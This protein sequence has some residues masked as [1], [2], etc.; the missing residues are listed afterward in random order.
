VKE[1]RNGVAGTS[2]MQ[3]THHVEPPYLERAF[4]IFQGAQTRRWSSIGA[5]EI[6]DVTR[7]E[8][9]RKCDRPAKQAE[10]STWLR[11]IIRFVFHFKELGEA[12]V[13]YVYVPLHVLLARVARFQAW[14]KSKRSNLFN[15][16]DQEKHGPSVT[17]PT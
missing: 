17:L 3:S 16:D 5:I 2:K 6:P 4:P 11:L 14:R 7:S 8:E 1:E 12:K 10:A 15:I 9:D 13:F